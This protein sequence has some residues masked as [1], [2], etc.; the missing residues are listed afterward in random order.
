MPLNSKK[1]ALLVL[2]MHRS[3]TSCVARVVNLLGH[4]LGADVRP[5]APDNPTGFWEHLSSSEL[6]EEIFVRLG[7]TWQS[8][9][10]LALD[11]WKG[12]ELVELRQHLL[13]TLRTGFSGEASIA[14]KDP[15][16]SLLVPLW[17]DVLAELDYEPR[18]LLVLREA[19]EVAASLAQRDGI[20][21]FSSE[22]LWL[23]YILSAEESTRGYS[24]GVIAYGDIVRDWRGA[25]GGLDKA[26]GLAP[27]PEGSELERKIEDFIRAD[28]RHHQ[29]GAST[30]N[31]SPWTDRVQKALESEGALSNSACLGE[32]D[33]IRAEIKAADEFYFEP[34]P[35]Q[36]TRALHGQVA[37]SRPGQVFPGAE[38]GEPSSA[39]QE[40][41]LSALLEKAAE[42]YRELSADL[43]RNLEALSST[44]DSRLTAMNLEIR[45]QA[46]SLAGERRQL[47]REVETQ[48]GIVSELKSQNLLLEER[49]EKVVRKEVKPLVSENSGLKLALTNQKELVEALQKTSLLEGKVRESQSAA[50][51]QRESA[52]RAQ[53][54]GS[55]KD[56][57]MAQVELEESENAIRAIRNSRSWKVTRPLRELMEIVKGPS[58]DIFDPDLK[59]P[60][61]WRPLEPG[62]VFRQQFRSPVSA[63]AGIGVLF[64]TY[65]RANTNTVLV[66][67]LEK[68]SLF[69]TRKVL[70]ESALE[71]ADISD[72]QVTE[73]SFDTVLANANKKDLTIEVEAVGSRSESRV[74]VG[75]GAAVYAGKQLSPPLGDEP[76]SRGLLVLS[77]LKPVG[78][79][80]KSFAFIS[81]CPGDAYRYRCEHQA[82]MLR[83]NGYSVD[84][85][86]ADETPWETLLSHYSVVVAHRVPHTAEFEE[87]TRKSRERGV[88]VVF[89]TDDL[90]FA[91]EVEHQI[92]A[93]KQMSSSEKAL[94]LDGVQRYRRALELCDQV[95]VSTEGLERSLAKRVDK[96]VLVSRN[97][98]SDEMVLLAEKANKRKKSGDDCVRIAY[99]SGTPTHQADFVECLPSLVNV[100]AEKPQVRLVLVGHITL[101]EEL[102]GFLRQIELK[103]FMPWRDLPELYGEIDINLAPLE[104]DN[105]FTDGKSE[106][107]FLE[108][109]LQGIPTIASRVGGYPYV[110]RDAENG[111]VCESESEW[112]AALERLV[113]DE[114]LR[115]SIGDTARRDV[116]SQCVTRA[117]AAEMAKS[118]LG[119]LGAES[120]GHRPLRIAFV[121]RAPIAET[122]GGY[123]KIFYLVEFL[124][125]RGHDVRV[126]VEP[127]AHLANRSEKYIENFCRSHFECG[128][129][130]IVSGH[131]S[132]SECD[133]AVAT[134]W[135]TANV[136]NSLENAGLRTYFVQDDE[137]EFYSPG[138]PLREAAAATYHLPLLT[139]GIGR[140]ISELIGSRTGISYPHVDFALSPPFFQDS[141]FLEPKLKA[142]A[143]GENPSVLFFARPGIPRRA[144]ELGV[145]ALEIFSKLKPEVEIRF[146]GLEEEVSLPFE[147]VNLGVIDQ[148]SVVDEMRRASVHLS[149]SRTNT[150]TVIFEA[151]ACAAV[152]VELDVDTVTGLIQDLSTCVLAKDSPEAVCESLVGLFDEP[153]RMSEVAR[154]GYESV[155]RL[156]VENMCS[157]FESILVERSFR[158]NLVESSQS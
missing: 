148:S 85:F 29:S 32:L 14:V 136:V 110:I 157:Q 49:L 2:G 39:A 92:A 58:T 90:V 70:L 25:F 23:R 123:K 78:E 11:G 117:S 61:P 65:G 5:P 120:G 15:R 76:A 9:E 128:N 95:I 20:D 60:V 149:F 86:P 40:V 53:W 51:N 64:F 71:G 8:V 34:G 156:T 12:A 109:A 158:K 116:L 144:Y 26:L 112:Q 75:I 84:V 48:R 122:G 107:K 7:R 42:P 125:R 155:A 96:R 59:S 31:C 81:G 108:A 133:V 46:E 54:E 87:F 35:S 82:E 69:S 94:W 146:Y 129:A 24:R 138:D 57:S 98:L 145:Q 1:T 50:A 135:P 111:F 43:A 79:S 93:L 100:L 141:D 22:L 130:S 103:P 47:E 131:D 4:A 106:L 44:M 91:P 6:N 105:E 147:F 52:L 126:Y 56:L 33:T 143:N 62:V 119:F 38:S 67:L 10:P 113:E 63:L 73:L 102:K 132:I 101:P 28:L 127:I 153:G 17:V 124:A 89:D 140:Y 150:S 118:W 13:E 83:L 137:A 134:N 74:T 104:R 55:Q 30:E 142:I 88:H 139:I 72:G 27:P 152:A 68:R 45:K 66:R 80:A 18:F 37:A 41:D 3:G 77:F 154:A 99:F 36:S 114:S 19:S 115:R 121:L 97:R 151:M 21:R 16:L